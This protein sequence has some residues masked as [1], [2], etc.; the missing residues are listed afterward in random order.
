[1]TDRLTF[2]VLGCGSSAGVPRIG[3]HWG[4]CN[5]ENPK[6]TRLR[7]S[8]LVTRESASGITRVL[9][10]TG[11]DLR[12]QLLQANTGELD[13]VVFTH[14]HADHMHGID[15]LRQVVFNVGRRLDVWADAPTTDALID[16]F[17]Y[18]FI[19]PPGSAYPPILNLN[20]IEEGFEIAG[21]GGPIPFRPFRANHGAIDALGFRIG[22]VAYLPDALELYDDAWPAL[23]G[24]DC[25]I[26]GALRR[27]PHPTHAHLERT[28]GWIER[29]GP[30][31]AVLT[32]MHIDLDYDDVMAETP[33][34][35]IP[36]HDGL[37]LTYDI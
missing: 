16:R 24:L 33:D 6:N 19:Q 1:M 23:E 14:A 21:P 12:T 22:T 3:G 29:A 2:T 13:G 8:L 10:D 26:V 18:V 30:R 7:C 28:L 25:W 20:L 35:V 36:A 32:N 17:G 9:I 34:N 15:D 27:K 5:P 11:P 4:E 37:V 31:K